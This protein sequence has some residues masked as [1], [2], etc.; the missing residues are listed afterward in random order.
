MA[1]KLF[2]LQRALIPLASGKRH[3]ATWHIDC[4]EMQ[5]R[6]SVKYE[7]H[8]HI[9]EKLLRG[10]PRIVFGCVGAKQSINRSPAKVGDGLSHQ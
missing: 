7:E 2:A 3:L 8:R 1:E 4:S 10:H 6:S 9:E 5:E